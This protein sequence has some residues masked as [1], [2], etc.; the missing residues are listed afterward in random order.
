MTEAGA[1]DEL[2]GE[3]PVSGL[4][5]AALLAGCGSALVLFTSLAAMLPLVAV[6]LAAVALVD[7]ARSD[8][9]RVGRGVALAGLALAI[10][11]A[12]QAA[13]GFVVDRWIG[14]RRAAATATAWIEAVREGRLADAIGLCT[15]TVLPAR[16]HDP[17]HQEPGAAD[18]TVTFQSLPAVAA[19]AACGREG[20]PA[21]TVHRDVAEAAVW[22]AQ[23][24]LSACGRTGGVVRLFLEPRAT[25]RGRESLERW[26]VTGFELVERAN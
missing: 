24:D 2:P 20:S 15:P 25:T 26:L 23:A 16:G 10:G 6:V 14:G 5:V 18:S 21:I 12:A 22:V 9:R 1:G 17:V 11:F 4:A 3:R 13:S 19:V 8:R 7:L